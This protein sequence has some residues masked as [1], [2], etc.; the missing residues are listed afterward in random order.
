MKLYLRP[1]ISIDK[2]ENRSSRKVNSE[3]SKLIP[4]EKFTI[5][6]N[7]RRDQR[8]VEMSLSHPHYH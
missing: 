7:S 3:S 1:R 2:I 4:F 6:R 8:S 5:Y